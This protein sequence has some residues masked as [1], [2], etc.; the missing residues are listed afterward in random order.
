MED[1][2]EALELIERN[3]DQADFDGPGN[4]HTK[5]GRFGH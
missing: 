1:F 4:A 5:G 3:D 2:E